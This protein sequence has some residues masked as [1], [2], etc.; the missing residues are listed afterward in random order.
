MMKDYK[1]LKCM[2]R[3]RVVFEKLGVDYDIMRRILQIKL[4]LDGRRVP[5][6]INN[7]GKQK[8][9]KKES[10][11]FFKSLWIYGLMGLLMVPFIL[12]GDNYIFQMSIVFGILIFMV[13]TSLISDFSSVILDIRDKNI[14]FSKPVSSKTISMAKT[15]HVFIY[16][17]YIT[18][19]LTGIP[20]IVSLVRHG[21]PFFI[22]FLFEIILVDLF[23][24]VITALLYL[25]ILKFFDG[26]KLKDVI[27]YVQILLSITITLGYQLIVRLFGIMDFN[28]VFQ[29]K[30][31]QYF[32][33]PIWFGAPFQW[34]I[35]KTSNSHYIA[36]SV[37]AIIIPIVSII[38]YIRLIPTFEKNLQKLNNNNERRKKSNGSALQVLSKILCSNR[39]ERIF[40]RFAS[41]MMRN[42]REF[43]LK[44]Y[45]A[46]GFSFIFPFIFIFN[47]LQYRG[48]E[49]IASGNSYFNI[50]LC[51][52]LLPTVTMMIKYSG[53]HKGAWIYKVIPLKEVAPIYK[54]TIKALVS[55]LFLPIYSIECIIFMS[56]FGMRIFWDLFV[57]FLN[58]LLFTVICFKILKKSLPF[59]EAFEA[60]Q[61][62]NGLIVFPLMLIMGALGAV[63]FAFTLFPY[64]VF[65]FIVILILVNFLLWKKAF[66][67]S[68]YGAKKH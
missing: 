40:F 31:W 62:N 26:E 66:I 12:M 64:G 25:L 56:I 60:T 11:K 44:V 59:S 13:T 3:L 34:I 55:R 15:I 28:M 9:E 2:D 46:L 6:I 35:Q 27:N 22:L 68:S 16:M 19:S 23:I 4:T 67:L 32:I 54:G 10:N 33:I 47:Q 49:S 63:H 41:N 61:Q 36:F 38:I 21:I 45:P 57:V 65:L 51:A 7:A 50:Y 17:F 1:V 42:E 24:I 29:P 20:L 58:I 53:K 48:F 30:W 52:L 5:T 14:I 8:T 39:E 37:L 18:L 43:K